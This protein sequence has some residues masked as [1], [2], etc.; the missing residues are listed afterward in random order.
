[1]D[2]QFEDAV[3]GFVERFEAVFH[4]DWEHTGAV[5]KDPE[6]YIGDSG[7]FIKPG[8]VDESNNWWN[9]AGLLHEYRELRKLLNKRGHVSEYFPPE[10]EAQ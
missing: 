9:R 10:S 1:M 5:L 8:V 4:A 7:T 6:G 2:K 3:I